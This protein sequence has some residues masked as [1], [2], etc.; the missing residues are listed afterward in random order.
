MRAKI[1]LLLAVVQNNS[2]IFRSKYNS[3]AKLYF[4]LIF[5]S[6]MLPSLENAMFLIITRHLDNC[7]N[8]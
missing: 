1:L 6:Q 3:A 5:T 8:N 4:K 2:T 7:W